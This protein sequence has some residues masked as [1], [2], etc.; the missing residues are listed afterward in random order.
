MR[1]QRAMGKIQ[2]NT[3]TIRGTA[4]RFKGDQKQKN[5]KILIIDNFSPGT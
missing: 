2:S 3:I 1:G 4:G 5:L